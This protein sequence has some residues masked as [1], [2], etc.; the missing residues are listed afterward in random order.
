MVQLSVT[1][2]NRL[3]TLTVKWT[4]GGAGVASAVL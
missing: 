3:Q 1:R 2:T 4:A